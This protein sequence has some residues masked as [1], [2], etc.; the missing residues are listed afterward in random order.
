MNALLGG[1]DHI[2]VDP[3]NGDVYV[4]VGSQDPYTHNN[5]LVF[6][7]LTSD[8]HGGLKQVGSSFVTGQINLALPSVAVA[9][10]S[11]GT[12]GVLYTNFDGIDAKTKLPKFTVWLATSDDHGKT[13]NH[14]ALETFLSPTTDNGD[15]RQRVLGDYQQLKS[16]GS[17]FYGVFA[18]NGVPFG[19]PF[20]NIDPIFF[21]T[22][23]SD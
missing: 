10:N 4:V 1:I 19:R 8:G 23:V 3:N 22:T 14:T 15:S 16:V 21:T 6:L 13:F 17:T 9:Q 7:H 18:G 11:K 5:R 12:I 2:A 20:A